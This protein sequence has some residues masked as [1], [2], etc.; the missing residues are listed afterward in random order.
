MSK[1]QKNENKGI[2]VSLIQSGFRNP[3]FCQKNG[4][5]DAGLIAA[6]PGFSEQESETQNRRSQWPCPYGNSQ[7]GLIV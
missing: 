2:P 1:L 5:T 6:Q 4:I 3:F 7:I